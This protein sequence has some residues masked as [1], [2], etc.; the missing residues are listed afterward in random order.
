VPFAWV[1]PLLACAGVVLVA[2]G[3]CG[4]ILLLRS[5]GR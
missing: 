3:I 1:G 4:S 2:R 5:A